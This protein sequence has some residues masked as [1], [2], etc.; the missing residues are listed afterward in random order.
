[1]KY[2]VGDKV[3]IVSKWNAHSCQNRGGRMDKWLGKVMTIRE[4][5]GCDYRMV[6]DQTEN[7]MARG[8]YW[9]EYC[10]AGLAPEHTQEI[11]ITT[12]GKETLARLY[13]DGKVVKTAS[14]KCSPEDTFDFETGAKIAF[15]RLVS[16]TEKTETKKPKFEVGKY[17]KHSEHIDN[18]FFKT[19]IGDGVI[20]ITA[21][22]DGQVDYE[23]IEGMKGDTSQHSFGDHSYFA[24]N[25]TLIENYGKEPE[26]KFVPH[27]VIDTRF[28]GNLGESTNYKDVLNRP[29]RVGDTVEHF[30][31]DGRCLGETVI[32][33][34][35][36]GAFVMGIRGKCN[37]SDG[38]I[39]G[40]WK[41]IKKRSFEEVKD[42][43]KVFLGIKYVKSER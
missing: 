29:L 12:D 40:G 33:K 41:I 27:L 6:E 38:T 14:A 30:D 39:G 2:K 10:I 8:W 32:V 34:D 24:S 11:V 28:L 35:D 1:M 20:K 16:K 42:G 13:E 15:E 7:G 5:D 25:L 23:I 22:K 19:K 31:P 9:N 43:E 21:V 4:I 36:R 37:D 3:R 26:K 17:Y 18:P